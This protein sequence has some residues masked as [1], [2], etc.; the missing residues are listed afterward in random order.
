MALAIPIEI[1]YTGDTCPCQKNLNYFVQK[2]GPPPQPCM[3]QKTSEYGY[4]MDVPVQGTS[5]VVYNFDFTVL[6]PKSTPPREQPKLNLYAKMDRIVTP[7][8]GI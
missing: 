2:P 6:E 4:K 5:E 7:K 8:K 3:E 1:I